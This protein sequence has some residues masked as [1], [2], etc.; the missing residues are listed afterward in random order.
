MQGLQSIGRFLNTAGQ[1]LQV[2]IPRSFGIALGAKRS[3]RR[4]HRWIVCLSERKDCG[5][6]SFLGRQLKKPSRR[7]DIALAQ[8]RGGVRQ[9]SSY[10]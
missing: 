2:Q 8:G 5:S 6:A 1:G 4:E 3:P 7:D 9:Q 10:V